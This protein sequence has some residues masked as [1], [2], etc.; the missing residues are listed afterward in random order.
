MQLLPILTKSKNVHSNHLS[1]AEDDDDA[2]LP[3]LD[4][5]AQASTWKSNQNRVISA[6][7]T[8]DPQTGFSSIRT[9]F[10]FV[11]NNFDG[12]TF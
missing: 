8:G 1:S 12:N 9:Y 5:L 10:Y 2:Q 6:T 4:Q 7:Y 11:D 3:F